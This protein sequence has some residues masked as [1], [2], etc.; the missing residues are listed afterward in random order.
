MPMEQKNQQ[1]DQKSPVIIFD[2]GGVL[3][4]WDPFYLYRKILGEDRPAMDRFLKEV[5]FYTWN[6][7]NDRGR[8]FATGTA[9]LSA[10]FPKYRDLIR[11]YD[12]RFP[13]TLSG[14]I[15]PVVEILR[16]LKVAGYPLYGLSN[17]SA[18]KFA[19]VR[20][21]YPFFEWFDDMVIS[22]EVR[23]LKPERAIFELLLERI[24]RPAGE[25]LFID[26]HSPNITA[27]KELGFQTIHFQNPQQLEAELHRK[28][29]LN[30]HIPAIL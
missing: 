8:P 14:A 21:Q 19:L 12:E 13:E 20:P 30:E 29:V 11:A 1:K 3:M 15:Q 7:E 24:G 16:K 2:F 17:W 6:L 22:G 25:C 23:L 28:G 4:D 26:D 10:R 9:E 18:E 27:A 5:D